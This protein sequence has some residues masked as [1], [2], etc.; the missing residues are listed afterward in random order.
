MQSGKP[1]EVRVL[2]RTL[3]ALVAEL[4]YA[5]DLSSV[6]CEFKSHRGYNGGFV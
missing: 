1:V 4:E 3:Y 6:I 5:S 2:L